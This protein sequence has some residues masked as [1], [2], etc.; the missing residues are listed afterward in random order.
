MVDT[1]ARQKLPSTL[2]D[3]KR[4]QAHLA[5]DLSVSPHT[6]WLWVHGISR[7]TSEKRLRIAE[8]LKIPAPDWLTAEERSAAGLPPLASTPTHA[9]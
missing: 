7:P 5:R 1:P 4:T 6:V 9:S 3:Q 8:L 2:A